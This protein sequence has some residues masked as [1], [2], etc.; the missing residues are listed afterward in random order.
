LPRRAREDAGLVLGDEA[1]ASALDEIVSKL[2]R[3]PLIR[4]RSQIG[5]GVGS[6]LG[7]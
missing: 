7:E 1:I 4:H 6:G 2:K 3:Q 5:L